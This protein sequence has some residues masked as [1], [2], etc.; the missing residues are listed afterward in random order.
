M[1]S[2]KRI[3]I[4]EDSDDTRFVYAAILSLDGYEIFEAAD[5]EAGVASALENRPDLIITDINMPGL[6]GFDVARRVRADERIAGT[7]IVAVTGTVFRAHEAFRG[8]GGGAEAAGGRVAA[9][10]AAV[11]RL[12]ESGGH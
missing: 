5:G 6:N 3:L 7:P 12:V 4:V 1:Q 11:A 2:R 10:G 9:G 8:P